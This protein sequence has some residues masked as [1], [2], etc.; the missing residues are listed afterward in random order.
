MDPITLIVAALAAGVSTGVQD[1]AADG[2]RNAYTTLR[3]LIKRRFA[4]ESSAESEGVEPTTVLD[5]HAKDPKTWE[6]P[7][8]EAL[9][10]AGADGDRAIIE[11]ATEL[12]RQADPEGTSQGKYVVDARGAQGVQIGDHG[13]MRV[14][15]NSPR[16]DPQAGAE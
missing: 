4:D 13:T 2:I 11:A 15:F 10:S 1:L 5:A 12:L 3:D 9:K 16:P 6:A 14:T 7:L 8:A